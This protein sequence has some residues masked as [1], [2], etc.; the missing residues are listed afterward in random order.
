MKKMVETNELTQLNQ[1]NNESEDKLNPKHYL[2]LK[3]GIANLI[4]FGTFSK[5]RLQKKDVYRKT[6]EE[7]NKL[8]TLYQ[9]ICCLIIHF[10]LIANISTVVYFLYTFWKYGEIRKLAQSIILFLIYLTSVFA[11][12]LSFYYRK[13]TKYL[14]N[15]ICDKD[16]II[17]SIKAEN[18]VNKSSSSQ[19]RIDGNDKSNKSENICYLKVFFKFRDNTLKAVETNKLMLLFTFVPPIICIVTSVVIL[20][21]KITQFDWINIQYSFFIFNTGLI[22]YKIIFHI[23]ITILLIIKFIG[24]NKFIQK[25]IVEKNTRQEE[26]EKIIKW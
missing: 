5:N 8:Y 22:L 26:L 11:Y 14:F 21:I 3:Y 12:D 18:E 20:I 24:L 19:Q 4:G 23:I 17:N 10:S 16:F 2:M 15:D 1:V 13:I 7:Y 9:V 6:I 25:L